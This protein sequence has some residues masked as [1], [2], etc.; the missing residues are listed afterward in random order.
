MVRGDTGGCG[1]DVENTGS[2]NGKY[3]KLLGV[4]A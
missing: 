3:R 2:N 4:L 1:D